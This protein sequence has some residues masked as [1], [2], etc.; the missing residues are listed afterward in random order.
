MCG[1][2][3]K[4]HFFL[5]EMC[6][7]CTRTSTTQPQTPPQPPSD[8][9]TITHWVYLCVSVICEFQ[10]Y[11]DTAET[12]TEPRPEPQ[13]KQQTNQPR[14]H[15]RTNPQNHGQ[16]HRQ[17]K[18]G[19]A[20]ERTPKP[21]IQTN[22]TTTA[23]LQPNAAETTLLPLPEWVSEIEITMCQPHTTAS[24][25]KQANNTAN[26]QQKHSRTNLETA[27]EASTERTAERQQKSQPN[28]PRNRSRI[29]HR[30]K[31]RTASRTNPKTTAETTTERSSSH[32]KTALQL[33]R[34]TE[35]TYGTTTKM[36][37]TTNAKYTNIKK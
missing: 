37:T 14:N 12:I 13:S 2:L 9:S 33:I 10:S 23:K 28:R 11:G 32:C 7:P 6:N 5:C 22:P 21:H 30:T 20:A 3:S 19:T 24:Q 36:A 1:W 31:S 15:S 16:N 34:T 25:S 18:T 26:I 35:I 27:S 29:H 17:T 8:P 4:S